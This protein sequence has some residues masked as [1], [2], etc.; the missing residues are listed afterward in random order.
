MTS[1]AVSSIGPGTPKRGG[2]RRPRDIQRAV[3]LVGGLLT[4]AYV[5]TPLQE[6]AAF[7]LLIKV[8][9]LPVV[10]AAGV[11]MWQLPRLR[12]LLQRRAQATGGSPAARAA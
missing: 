4:A 2:N 12:R 5:Y 11:A 1:R 9:A 8:V 3:H 7:D 10:A 6:V